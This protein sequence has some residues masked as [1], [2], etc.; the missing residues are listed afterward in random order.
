M[1]I[2]TKGENKTNIYFN[3]L[4]EIKCLNFIYNLWTNIKKKRIEF[5]FC[6]WNLFKSKSQTLDTFQINNKKYLTEF[7]RFVLDRSWAQFSNTQRSYCHHVVKCAVMVQIQT[8]SRIAFHQTYAALA[9]FL[10]TLHLFSAEKV[11]SFF[12][13]VSHV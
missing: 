6:H 13:I 7:A 10:I 8:A 11:N 5:F 1:Y 3:W 12:N 4:R 9:F 2:D